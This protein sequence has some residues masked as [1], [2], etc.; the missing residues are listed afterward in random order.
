MIYAS[1]IEN[2]D[3]KFSTKSHTAICRA[4]FLKQIN[5]YYFGKV[6]LEFSFIL[7]LLTFHYYI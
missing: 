4:V 3:F 5:N 2:D 1:D 6:L 7:I